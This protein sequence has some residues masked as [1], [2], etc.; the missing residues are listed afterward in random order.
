MNREEWLTKA[1]DRVRLH[2]ASVGV[3]VPTNVRVSIGFPS[4]RAIGSRSGRVVGQCFHPPASSDASFQIFISPVHV[5]TEAILDTLVHELTHAAV[6]PNRGHRSAFQQAA[7]KMGLV[8]PRWTSAGFPNGVLPDWAAAIVTDLG[9]I[10]HPALDPGQLAGK[11][12]TTRMVK[13]QCPGCA[14]ILRTT[15]KWI[16]V[17]VPTCCCGQVFEVTEAPAEIP[18]ITV[19]KTREVFIP[20]PTSTDP[21]SS[22]PV[23]EEI[24]GGWILG[25][26][27]DTERVKVEFKPVTEEFISYTEGLKAKIKARLSALRSQPPSRRANRLP[28]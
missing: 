15:A 13:L 3:T 1:A 25:D 6:S 18:Q 11:P 23:P 28:A 27:L 2:G 16:A 5:T 26:I 19:V 12:Q 17:G 22:V 20:V 14:Y 21:I 8:G 7:A 10:P 4:T 9:P 24:K